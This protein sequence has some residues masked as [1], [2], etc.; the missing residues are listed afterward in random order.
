MAVSCH[1]HFKDYRLPLGDRP[2]FLKIFQTLYE[3]MTDPNGEQNCE[4]LR[5]YEKSATAG[6]N[7]GMSNPR[8]RG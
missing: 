6:E 8:H 1:L 3:E 5:M 4:N 7:G 2:S